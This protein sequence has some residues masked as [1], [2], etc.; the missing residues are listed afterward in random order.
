MKKMFK[1][2]HIIGLL[3]ALIFVNVSCSKDD[4]AAV[5]P[6][7]A[8]PAD[9]WVG[10][11]EGTVT[12]RNTRTGSTESATITYIFTK[13][14]AEVV[15]ISASTQSPVELVVQGN[16]VS[17]AGVTFQML[18]DKKSLNMSGSTSAASNIRG[19][20]YKK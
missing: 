12:F 17:I 18:S 4:V 19:V 10:T 11:W 7:V 2:F 8:D 6:V 20:L 15:I 16:N 3:L 1:K 9:A 13:K 14:A 5:V